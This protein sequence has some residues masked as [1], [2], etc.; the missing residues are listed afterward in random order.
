[1]WFLVFNYVHVATRSFMIH[2]KMCFSKKKARLK[3]QDI[4]GVPSIIIANRPDTWAFLYGR[5]IS[6]SWIY[7]VA[8][9]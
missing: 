9:Y 3:I 6:Y 5:M 2:E 7:I 1:M 4:L 8:F